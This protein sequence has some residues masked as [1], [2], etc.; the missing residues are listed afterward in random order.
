MIICTILSL[1]MAILGMH[2][3][4]LHREAKIY[5]EDVWDNRHFCGRTLLRFLIWRN[6]TSPCVIE[7]LVSEFVAEHQ[8]GLVRVAAAILRAPASALPRHSSLSRP[9]HAPLRGGGGHKAAHGHQGP[10]RDQDQTSLRPQHGHGQQLPRRDRPS[11]P[12]GLLCPLFLYSAEKMLFLFRTQLGSSTS[13][14][15]WEMEPTARF[16]HPTLK[17]FPLVWLT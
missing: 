11:G 8:R 7:S 14:K 1:N 12:Q 13:W 16:D 2:W 9:H 17:I 4:R 6:K 3:W 5:W 15:L 10:F